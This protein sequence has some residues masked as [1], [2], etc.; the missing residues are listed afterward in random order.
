VIRTYHLL[1][2]FAEM[3]GHGRSAGQTPFEYAR[4]LAQVAPAERD[5][6]RWL[7]WAY[8]GA[9]YAGESAAMPPAGHVQQAWRRIAGALQRGLT[10]EELELRRRAYLAARALEEQSRR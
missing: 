10:P 8:A 3:L 9:M 2:D 1:L 5:A 6:L 7:T 4:G